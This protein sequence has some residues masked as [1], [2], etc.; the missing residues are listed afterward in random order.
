[1]N[2]EDEDLVFRELYKRLA[3]ERSKARYEANANIS[4]EI[5]NRMIE[6][7]FHRYNEILRFLS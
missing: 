1:M 6:I 3:K 7:G 5:L 4:P 2:S